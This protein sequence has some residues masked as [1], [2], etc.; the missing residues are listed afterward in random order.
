MSAILQI[1]EKIGDTAPFFVSLA[2]IY[3]ISRFILPKI[4][5]K[6]SILFHIFWGLPIALLCSGKSLPIAL[7]YIILAYF[8]LDL[9]P[10]QCGII[11]YCLNVAL[12]AYGYFFTR[13]WSLDL[14]V[15]TMVVCQKTI[16]LCFNIADGTQNQE[17]IRKRFAQVSVQKKPS[18]LEFAAY[19]L[20]PIGSFTNPFIEYKIFDFVLDRGERPEPTSD[21]D[22]HNANFKF[23]GSF[24]W[25]FETLLVMKFVSYDWYYSDWYLNLNF[26]IRSLVVIVSSFL[27]VCR[28]FCVWW[29]VEAGLSEVGAFSSKIVPDD[30]ASNLSFWKILQSGTIQNWMR[31]WNHTT[32]L[33]WKNYLMVRLLI[34]KISPLL[35]NRA[36]FIASCGWHGVR[37]VYFLMVPE[38]FL[39]LQADASLDKAYPYQDIRSPVLRFIRKFWVAYEM[40][41]TVSTWFYPSSSEF[42]YLRKTVYFFPSIISAL[43]LIFSNIVL[44]KKKKVAHKEE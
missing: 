9:S 28:Y 6:T 1:I 16:S 21:I 8:L 7:G 30:E 3:P 32:H 36:V 4:K 42:F 14:T 13:G 31:N 5:R 29:M 10:K 44:L 22:R 11:N 34:N 35:A 33:F 39:A 38:M 20:T 23:F 40:L 2:T 27:L 41:Y 17:E 37:P 19:C 15:L 26:L 18:F 25:V 43:V 12:Q 24:L